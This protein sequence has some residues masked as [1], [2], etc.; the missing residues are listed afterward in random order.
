MHT[1]SHQRYMQTYCCITRIFYCK[2]PILWRIENWCL[3]LEQ[4][5]GEDKHMSHECCSMK[6][7][8]SPSQDRTS[9]ARMRKIK[10][11]CSWEIRGTVKMKT[12]SQK[13]VFSSPASRNG[14]KKHSTQPSG[15]LYEQ[16]KQSPTKIWG[17]NGGRSRRLYYWWWNMRD[18]RST[19][20]Y[21]E[22]AIIQGSWKRRGIGWLLANAC[23]FIFHSA[24]TWMNIVLTYMINYNGKFCRRLSSRIT[25]GTIVTSSVRIRWPETP[26]R[27]CV[28]LSIIHSKTPV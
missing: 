5:Q 15:H 28:N 4:G 25:G 11:E 26:Q 6:S 3:N 10:F 22:G 17:L 21:W 16:Q 20:M 8:P 2:R 23:K 7:H 12:N 13:V 19:W 14:Q 9:D 1:N 24:G 18:S 27:Q